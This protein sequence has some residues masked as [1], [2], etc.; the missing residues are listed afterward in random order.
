MPVITPALVPSIAAGNVFS[1]LTSDT[2][3]NVRWFTSLDP[4]FYEVLNRPIADCVL[5]QL[6]LA[7]SLDQV[8]LGVGRQNRFPFILQP[9]VEN[10]TADVDIPQ[11]WIWDLSI[12]A[13]NKWKNFRLAKIKRLSGSE[14]TEG[15]TGILRLIFTANANNS[16]VEIAVFSADYE[17]HSI[18][19]WQRSRLTVVTNA[20]ESVVIDANERTTVDGYITFRTLDATL[21]DV[22]A[23]FDVLDPGG[24][25]TDL[26]SDGIYDDPYEVEL[27]NAAAGTGSDES[28]SANGV[29]H[30]TGLLT[31]GVFNA[32]PP[33]DT[34]LEAWILAFN[35]PF[36][37]AA[38][39]TSTGT[40]NIEIP[41][42]MF[43]EFNITAPAGDLPSDD[44]SG[45]YYPVWLSKIRKVDTSTQLELVFSTYSTNVSTPSVEP[46]E[47]ASLIIDPTY[48]SGQILAINPLDNLLFETGTNAG[49]FDQHFG[50]GHVVLSSK[51]DGSD[52][53]IAEFF[54]AF[55]ELGVDEVEYTYASTRL[56]VF[57]VSRVPKYVPTRGQ[58]EALLGSMS[59]R[60][61][62]VPPSANNRFVTE[63]DQGEGDRVDLDT[64]L[65]ESIT[66]IERYGYKGALVH[67]A[68]TLVIDHAQ[69]DE[70]YANDTNFYQEHI[71]PRLTLL[72]GRAP[73]KF[74]EW[75]DGTRRRFWNGSTWQD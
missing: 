13:P 21:A 47:F 60:L 4:V 20:E 61:I 5:R 24:N 59:T 12:S 72:L 71:L 74:D 40:I 53:E 66:G 51:W 30:G 11:A 9:K 7:K 48:I 10:G 75:Y 54:A 67:R 28:Y 56:N 45:E 49:L 34:S 27:V 35:Y 8:S 43:D 2:S 57:S 26:N 36:D 14:T 52:T 15:I 73:V 63:Q 22:A 25:I 64:S 69:I 19:T 1:R 50:R 46:I 44:I 65:G 23:F 3:L 18:L 38:S 6:I 32:I 42:G 17:I 70:N 68:V 37:Q 41:T 39:R 62:P 33:L 31:D 29:T 16:P 58:A 55:D